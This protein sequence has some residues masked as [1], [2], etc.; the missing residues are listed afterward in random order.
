MTT[1]TF[2]IYVA[3]S[4]RNPYYDAIVEQLRSRGYAPYDWKAYGFNW[5]EVAA[6]A[7]IDCGTSPDSNPTV[8]GVE[9]ATFLDHPRSEEHFL[10]D[11][12]AM[13]ASGICV[14]V[15]PS[16]RSAH[17]E[18]GYM[19]GQGKPSIVYQP[20]EVTV[21]P[22]LLYGLAG[23]IVS[24]IEDLADQ[25]DGFGLGRGGQRIRG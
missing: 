4:W 19:V 20:I 13:D 18:Y 22:E 21:E 14:L 5:R 11:K 8:T 2:N 9:M 17:A 6:S 23:T 12:Q 7:G 10:R 16:G 24:N 25:L 15:L 3:S 1:E